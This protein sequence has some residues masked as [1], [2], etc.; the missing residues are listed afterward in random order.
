MGLDILG[1]FRFGYLF[2]DPGEYVFS[3]GNANLVNQNIS[4]MNK[5]I[6]IKDTNKKNKPCTHTYIHTFTHTCVHTYR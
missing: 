3:N 5:K 6:P 4:S 1:S 2:I